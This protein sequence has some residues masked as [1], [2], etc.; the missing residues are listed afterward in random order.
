MPINT[1]DIKEWIKSH[2]GEI[3]EPKDV[4]ARFCVSYEYLRRQ[5]RAREGVT[6]AGFIRTCRV[7][8]LVSLVQ[9]PDSRCGEA[10]GTAGFGTRQSALRATK[11]MTGLTLRELHHHENT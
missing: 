7:K 5:F 1:T 3:K 10:A 8:A 11:A 4:S 6:L 9:Q 2:P